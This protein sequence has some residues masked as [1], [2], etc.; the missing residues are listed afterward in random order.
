MKVWTVAALAGLGAMTAAQAADPKLAPFGL[1]WG[2]TQAQV[3]ALGIALSDCETDD[4][5]TVCDAD[6]VPMPPPHASIDFYRVRFDKTD[7]GLASVTFATTTIKNDADGAK[8]KAIYETLRQDMVAAYGDA[9]ARTEK[10]E[11]ASPLGF[12]ECLKVDG[13]GTWRSEWFGGQMVL[14]IKGYE[15]GQGFVMENFYKP[16]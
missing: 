15:P 9:S 13:C 16:F 3:Q 1:S 14:S 11:P 2:Q 7:G 5:D 4:T 6:K 8:G 10:T 12:Y